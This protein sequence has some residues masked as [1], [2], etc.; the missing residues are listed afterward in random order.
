VQR[1]FDRS[2]PEK[3]GNVASAASEGRRQTGSAAQR[4]LLRG[5]ANQIRFSRDLRHQTFDPNLFGE[6]AW[7]ILLSLYIIDSDRRRLNVREL[8]KHANLALTTALRWLDYLEEQGLIARKANQFDR[9]VNYVELSDKGRA[10][11]DHYLVEMQE[12]AMFGTAPANF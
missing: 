11:M 2:V 12:A 7:D 4:E 6:P 3:P 1:Q 8:T 5:Y 10:A 9:R